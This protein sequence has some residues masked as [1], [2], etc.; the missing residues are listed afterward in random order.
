MPSSPASTAAYAFLKNSAS[1][2]FPELVSTVTPTSFSLV[3]A[4]RAARSVSRS[5]LKL[6]VM[7]SAPASFSRRILLATVLGMSHHLLSTITK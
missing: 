3:A 1:E 2:P 5:Q 7:M 4:L 6:T